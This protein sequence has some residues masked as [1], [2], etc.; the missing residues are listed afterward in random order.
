MAGTINTKKKKN[1]K[2]PQKIKLKSTEAT[3]YLAVHDIEA[4]TIDKYWCSFWMNKEVVC[5]CCKKI[6]DVKNMLPFYF[7]YIN[8][9]TIINTLKVFAILRKSQKIIL[10]SGLELH[11][12]EERIAIIERIVDENNNIIR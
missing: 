12:V 3:W 1:S 6:K 11:C 10:N 9:G 8:K 4:V 2:L 5:S 7:E